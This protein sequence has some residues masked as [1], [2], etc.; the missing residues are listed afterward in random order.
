VIKDILKDA[1]HRM[2]GAIKNLSDDLAAIRTG[3]ANPALVERL[4]IKRSTRA[5]LA[6]PVRMEERSSLRFL[7]A[8][9]M[10]CSASFRRSFITAAPEELVVLRI[11]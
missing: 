1:E 9:N 8:P 7:I 11:H 2:L 10:R 6:R 3:R 5:G 4:M